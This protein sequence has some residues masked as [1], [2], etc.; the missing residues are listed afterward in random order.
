[1]QKRSAK[2][3]TAP[4]KWAVSA[5]GHVSFGE[6]YEETATRELEEELGIR[7]PLYKMAKIY[8][9]KKMENGLI[10]NEIIMLYMCEHE[11]PF[12]LQESEVSEVKFV[13]IDELVW[14]I[15]EHSET[16]MHTLKDVIGLFFAD[17]D[18]SPEVKLISHD[19]IDYIDKENNVIGPVPKDEAHKKGLLHRAVWIIVINE[20]GEI[21]IQKRHKKKRI[22]PGFWDLS[23]TGHVDSGETY[24]EAAKRELSEELGIED[25]LEKIEDGLF[26]FD[27]KNGLKDRELYRIY[28]CKSDGPFKMQED[29]IEEIRFV[30]PEEL[31]E[32]INSGNEKLTNSLTIAF[33]KYKKKIKQA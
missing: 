29:E 4:G 27:H 15:H 21:L 7:A 11:G 2:K 33:E 20:K 10:E 19:M 24:D 6:S 1:I 23:A 16:I 5:A 28:L 30:S 25:T 12:N 18:T 3:D 22:S 26:V 9:Y 13:S 14:M 8:D 17:I 32:M 31:D